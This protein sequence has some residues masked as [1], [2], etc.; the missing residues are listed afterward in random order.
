MEVV[1][2]LLLTVRVFCF[3]DDLLNVYFTDDLHVGSDLR[4]CWDVEHI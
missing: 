1:D 3:P 4:H 2:F